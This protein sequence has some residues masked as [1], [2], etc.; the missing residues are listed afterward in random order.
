[1]RVGA[2]DVRHRQR[3]E[4]VQARGVPHFL[5]EGL[6]H[7][8]VVEIFFL[9]RFGHQQVFLHQ[10]RHQ[11]GVVLAQVVSLAKP[12]RGLGPQPGMIAPPPLGQVVEQARQIQQLLFGYL[13]QDVMAQ[14][15]PRGVLVQAEAPQV[16]DHE[17]DVLV[18]RIDM[19]QVELHQAL[20]HG[21]LRQIGAQDPV[22][23]H[24]LQ[25]MS[26]PA[27]LADDLQEQ[28]LVSDVL[29][30]PVVYE[31]QGLPDEPHRAGSDALDAWILLQ[32]QEDL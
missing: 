32:Q 31:N 13:P 9:R 16:S 15:K 25:L 26:H 21:E 1:M 18:H 28:A 12:P 23:V 19:E 22:F 4:I 11:P 6:D 30:E 24:A 14:G 29:P 27:R 2:V 8:R 5:G 17:Q 3:V 10:P 7:F 20:D